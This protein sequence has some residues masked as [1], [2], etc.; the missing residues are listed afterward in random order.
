MYSKPVSC[1]G[2]EQL[3]SPV[4]VV[5]REQP[6]NNYNVSDVI[7]E[8]KKFFHYKH[9]TIKEHTSCVKG[10]G[11]KSYASFRLRK[12]TITGLIVLFTHTHY[13]I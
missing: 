12:F 11:I 8:S 13:Y 3:R 6:Q 1:L 4:V 10:S 7:R 5:L 9:M 2:D